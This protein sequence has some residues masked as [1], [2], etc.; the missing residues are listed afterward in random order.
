MKKILVL[1]S[2]V[3]ISLSSFSQVLDGMFPYYEKEKVKKSDF[4]K[5]SYAISPD[6]DAIVLEEHIRITPSL[7]DIKSFLENGTT[8]P[9]TVTETVWRKIKILTDAGVAR[10]NVVIECPEKKVRCN[11]DSI[12]A[13]SYSLEDNKVVKSQLY[14]KQINIENMADGTTRLSFEIPNAKNGSIIEYGYTRSFIATDSYYDCLMQSDMPKL[15]SECYITVNEKYHQA[16]HCIALG[17]VG[18]EINKS[19]TLDWWISPPIQ[20]G[21]MTAQKSIKYSHSRNG[22]V[23]YGDTLFTTYSFAT[24]NLSA[25]QSTSDDVGVKVLF[26]DAAVK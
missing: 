24:E 13:Y 23:T 2:F 15:K 20:Y 26:T 16:F 18:M 8:S 1:I 3:T 22:G 6:A 11:E 7:V 19:T 5:M 17:G 4:R 12:E 9:M 10:A 21:N 14:S 25:A